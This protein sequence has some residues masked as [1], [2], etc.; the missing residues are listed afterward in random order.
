MELLRY[1]TGT[2]LRKVL[3]RE[4]M[5]DNDNG[6]AWSFPCEYIADHL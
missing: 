4:P 2:P 3:G 5:N 6:D 1:G